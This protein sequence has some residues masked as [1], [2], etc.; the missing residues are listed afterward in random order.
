MEQWQVNL[1]VFALGL[2]V[3]CANFE[4][5]Q[6]GAHGMP[7]QKYDQFWFD[8]VN[9]AAQVRHKSFDFG[10][11]RITVTWWSVFNDVGNVNLLSF[12]LNAFKHLV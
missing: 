11:L 8:D 6:N 2:S 3:T 5:R 4:F 7:A 1:A 10:W 12:K 9:L